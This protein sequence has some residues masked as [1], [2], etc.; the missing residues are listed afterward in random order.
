[1]GLCVERRGGVCRGRL[2]FQAVGVPMEPGSFPEGSTWSFSARN[3]IAIIQY[4]ILRC[5][6]DVQAWASAH[7]ARLAAEPSLRDSR[8]ELRV[9]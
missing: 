6:S 1:M 8:D 4:V 5:R 7:R 2:L 3:I 9:A